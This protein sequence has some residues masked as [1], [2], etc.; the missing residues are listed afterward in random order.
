[1][2]LDRHTKPLTGLAWNPRT[3]VLYHT[4]AQLGTLSAVDPL[5]G[6]TFSLASQLDKPR[7]ITAATDG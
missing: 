2:E 6:S 1:M 4:V 5:R 7:Q 3:R